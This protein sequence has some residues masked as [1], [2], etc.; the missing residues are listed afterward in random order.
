[1]SDGSDPGTPA[2]PTY[3][4]TFRGMYCNSET[5]W[6]GLSNSDEAYFQTFATWWD[7]AGDNHTDPLQHPVDT[8]IY[9]DVDDGEPRIGPVAA[10]WQGSR[11]PMSLTVVAWEHDYGD[12]DYYKAEI[13]AIVGAAAALVAYLYAPGP[14]AQALSAALVPLI[15]D[16][17]NWLIDTDDDRIGDPFI[18]VLDVAEME[19]YGRMLPSPYP[20]AS[21][22]SIANLQGHF[23]SSHKS[24]GAD[25]AA[26]FQVDRDP[27]L[28][29]DSGPIL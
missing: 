5:R 17:L 8:K 13:T 16:A 24:D 4:V 11:L 19:E 7:E 20:T 22:Q 27:A 23:F 29:R 14:L 25:Y 12:P 15:V 1:M 18:K 3:T 10:V 6:D 2:P 26:A 21:G 9:Q 28:P